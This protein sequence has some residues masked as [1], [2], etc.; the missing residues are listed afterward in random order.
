MVPEVRQSALR[1]LGD[2]YAFLRD[3][4]RMIKAYKDAYEVA[5]E[6]RTGQILK[7]NLEYYERMMNQ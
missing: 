7:R 2:T 4:P 5:P 3:I 6:S 1:A